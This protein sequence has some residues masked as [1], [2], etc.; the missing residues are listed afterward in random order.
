[1]IIANIEFRKDGTKKVDFFHYGLYDI[2]YTE[3]GYRYMRTSKRNYFVRIVDSQI[4]VSTFNSMERKVF[5]YIMDNFEYKFD[6]SK[7]IDFETFLEEYRSQRPFRNGNHCRNQLSY[8]FAPSIL[9][10]DAIL[11]N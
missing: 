2:A 10:I 8:E 4:R 3:L 9:E 1:M 6:I 7:V 11:E 5:K